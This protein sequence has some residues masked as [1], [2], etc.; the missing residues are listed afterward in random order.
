MHGLAHGVAHT[1]R[2]R[3]HSDH[4]WLDSPGFTGHLQEP[5]AHADEVRALFLDSTKMDMGAHWFRRGY[6]R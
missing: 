5:T 2:L 3:L 4:Y 6:R 1:E